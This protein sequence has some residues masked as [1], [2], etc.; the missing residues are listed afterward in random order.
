MKKKQN[1]Q[2]YKSK[3]VHWKFCPECWFKVANNQSVEG[4]NGITRAYFL[5]YPTRIGGIFH[6]GGIGDKITIVPTHKCDNKDAV[7]HR[8]VTIAQKYLPL[9]IDE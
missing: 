7:S 1:K 3:P 6:F 8:V 2:K 5:V 4:S 9:Q